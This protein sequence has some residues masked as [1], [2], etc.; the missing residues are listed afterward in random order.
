MPVINLLG[1]R[2]MSLLPSVVAGLIAAEQQCRHQYLPVLRD[3][4]SDL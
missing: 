1:E 4:A 3:G 2:H